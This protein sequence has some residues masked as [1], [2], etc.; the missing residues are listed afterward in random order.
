MHKEYDLIETTIKPALLETTAQLSEDIQEMEEQ[1]EKQ[2]GRIK[3]L[4]I[5]KVEEPGEWTV[6]TCD[7]KLMREICRRVFYGGFKPTQR[8]HHD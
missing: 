2:T 6:A 1:L 7:G 5:K 8:G 3:E 4:W